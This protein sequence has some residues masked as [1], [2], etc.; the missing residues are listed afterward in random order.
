MEFP[1]IKFPLITCRTEESGRVNSGNAGVDCLRGLSQARVERK[2]RACSLL[3]HRTSRRK[4]E[5]KVRVLLTEV[6][7]NDTFDDVPWVFRGRTHYTNCTSALYPDA[8]GHFRSKCNGK[9][10][11]EKDTFLVKYL[12]RIKSISYRTDPI[13]L[14]H[15][16]SK[17]S[18]S[19]LLIQMCLKCAVM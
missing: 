2:K 1:T 12:R 3:R 7:I 6:V 14:L 19:V 18:W 15:D 13:L 11:T 10:R 16:S 5:V 17:W 9:V 4:T 8:R